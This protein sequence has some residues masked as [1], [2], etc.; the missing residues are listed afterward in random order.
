[1]ERKDG[2]CDQGNRT[3]CQAGP[4]NAGQPELSLA[5]PTSDPRS[6]DL[7]DYDSRLRE[8]S[9]CVVRNSEVIQRLGRHA[10]ASGDSSRSCRLLAL[11]PT[12]VVRPS[13]CFRNVCVL[14][15]RRDERVTV[16]IRH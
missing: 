6:V 3:E 5:L 12:Q 8:V 7:A 15:L 14:G 10:V 16:E 1:M 9:V 13:L 4:S 11:Q 2:R